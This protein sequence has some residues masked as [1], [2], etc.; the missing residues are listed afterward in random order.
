MTRSSM[1]YFFFLLFLLAEGL[2]AQNKRFI[3]QYTFI[4]D[5]TNKAGVMKEFMFLDVS[6]GGSSFFSQR[7]YQSDSTM[8]AP[9][10]KGKM[11]M[12]PMDLQVLYTIEK[13]GDKIFY[14]TLGSSA[15]MKIK[16]NEDR[17]MDWKILNDRQKILNYDAQKA[18]LK[19]GGR[20][21][22][23]WF[24]QAIPMQDG[25]YKFHGLPGLIVKIEDTTASHI[26][27]LV[28]IANLPDDYSYPERYQFLKEVEFNRAEYQKYYTKYRKDPAAIEKQL[29][30]EGRIPD[31]RDHTGNFRTGAQVLR[32]IEIAAKENVK[33]DN[34]IIEIDMLKTVQ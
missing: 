30:I 8:I 24:T 9:A 3:Y 2:T 16:V 14:K 26:F 34:N 32:D 7:K 13:K 19:F 6:D 5:S 23:A 28:G 21:W 25:P 10:N 17:K 18:S 11:I 4:P 22:N 27:E 20:T 15:Q 33:K 31:Q 12:P 29:Y 1:K